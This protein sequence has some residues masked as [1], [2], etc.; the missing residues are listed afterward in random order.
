MTS[1]DWAARW[2]DGRTGF[3]EGRP[4]ELLQRHVGALRGARRILVPLCGKAVDLKFLADQGHEV[5]GVELVED[6]VVAFFAEHGLTPATHRR[7]PLTLYEAGA[8]TLV[9][10]DFFAVTNDVVGALDGFYD[11]AAMIALPPD[12]RTRYVQHLRSLTAGPG[13]VI[14]F[15]YPQELMAG[16]PF[17]V[18]EADVR[19]HY[20]GRQV[21]LL[22][23]HMI[24][25]QRIQSTAKESCLLVR[26]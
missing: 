10:G 25:H 4:N 19:A 26:A 15:D 14:S 23:A 12:V 17:S 11:R 16:P 13:I 1:E 18:S 3:H 22:E 5:V 24:T 21:D 9:V 20:D 2:R 8:I 7:G 6:A